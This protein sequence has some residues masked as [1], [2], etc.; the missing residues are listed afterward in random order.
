MRIAKSP[1]VVVFCCLLLI[2]LFAC[3]PYAGFK[4]VNKKGMSNG[5]APSQEL[6]EGY[7]K[8]NKKM[9]KK[10]KKEMKKR[11]KRMGSRPENTPS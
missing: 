10:Y 2:V 6:K 3:N 11:Q 9:N 5:K 7:K 1:N 8:A 4:G